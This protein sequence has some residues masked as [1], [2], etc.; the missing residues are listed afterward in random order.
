MNSLISRS[1]LLLGLITVVTS[2]CRLNC[3]K[4]EGAAEQRTLDVASFTGIT[5]DGPI[6]VTLEKGPAQMITATG[7]PNLLDLLNTSVSGETWRIATSRC[8]SSKEEIAVHIVTP[9]EIRAIELNGS[10]D[11]A[12]AD[13]FGRGDVEL[14]TRGSGSITVD[15]INAGKLSTR[16]T[17]SGSITIQGTCATLDA[18]ITGSGDL[19]GRGLTANDA[20]LD[21]TGSGSA[22][23]IAISKLKANVTGSGDVRYGGRP[24]L[25]SKITGSGSVAPLP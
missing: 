14:A 21:I 9:T 25:E 3:I 22:S 5:V 2:G 12:S 19:H 10:S 15:A 6:R 17:G 24:M 7:Q 13:V 20:T 1:L 11:V 4:G 16:I 23:I 8:W 18:G